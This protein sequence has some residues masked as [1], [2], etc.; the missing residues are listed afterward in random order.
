M[1][2]NTLVK[3]NFGIMRAQGISGFSFHLLYRA[4]VIP[5][6]RPSVIN[7]SHD[8]PDCTANSYGNPQPHSQQI[9]NHNQNKPPNM[10]VPANTRGLNP[11]PNTSQSASPSLLAPGRITTSAVSLPSWDTTLPILRFD[12]PNA[13]TQA[14][15]HR[16][17][18]QIRSEKDKVAFMTRF[19]EN[20]DG[21]VSIP[22][23]VIMDTSRDEALAKRVQDS[24]GV[25]METSRDEE[26]ARRL[27]QEM[28]RVAL[29]EGRRNDEEMARLMQ[30]RLDWERQRQRHGGA[31]RM[32]DQFG[33]MSIRG[34]DAYP[35][36]R[37]PGFGGNAGYGYVPQRRP[38]LPAYYD[39]GQDNGGPYPPGYIPGNE[40]GPGYGDWGYHRGGY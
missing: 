12:F 28:Q 34:R 10:S 40:Y 5:P 30:R 35:G 39:E 37:G 2:V 17:F 33:G 31:D 18:A 21:Q 27:Q 1:C 14:T 26:V 25:E 23:R 22:R 20:Y 7:P 29:D 4:V 15:F 16:A 32:T 24:L 19:F 6:D 38:R 13:Q 9:H 3:A 11:R 8:L 36:P